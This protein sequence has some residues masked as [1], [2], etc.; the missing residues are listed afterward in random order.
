MPVIARAYTDLTGSKIGDCSHFWD[1]AVG[2]L[3]FGRL[4]VVYYR[5][6][7]I[8]PFK[9][10]LKSSKHTNTHKPVVWFQVSS[11]AAP[12]RTASCRPAPT[13]RVERNGS[14]GLECSGKIAF[15]NS[16]S[17]RSG[18]RR[19]ARP[20]PSTPRAHSCCALQL[21]RRSA[22]EC[23]QWRDSAQR[24][25]VA[26]QE[27]KGDRGWRTRL[28][29]TQRRYTGYLGRSATKDGEAPAAPGGADCRQRRAAC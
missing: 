16:L 1:S 15:A 3:I 12:L 27:R 29:H 19:F 18:S 20:E 22:G 9:F 14:T 5:I 28:H 26:R 13:R 2:E 17:P 25:R 4:L 21:P 24:A 8:F 11:C 7:K 6:A 23:A 10:G